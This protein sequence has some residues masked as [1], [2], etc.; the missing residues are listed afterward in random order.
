MGAVLAGLGQPWVDEGE[1]WRGAGIS[2]LSSC[3]GLG[4]LANIASSSIS[5][6]APK[7]SQSDG[8][9]VPRAL[10]LT[11]SSRGGGGVGFLNEGG[12]GEAVEVGA[13]CECRLANAIELTES[14]RADTG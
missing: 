9:P 4:F 2:V 14:V 10:N 1:G 13:R 11:A 7:V 6:P 8:P 12:F 5:S 3:T